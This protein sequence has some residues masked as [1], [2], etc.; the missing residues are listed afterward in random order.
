[1]IDT[2]L[3]KAESYLGNQNIKKSGISV[4]WTDEM[5]KEY[6]KCMNDPLYFAEKYIKI[7]TID[8]GFVPIKLYDFQKDILEKISN[9]RRVVVGA[10]RQSG[11]TTVSTAVILHYVLFNNHKTVALLAN[12]ASAAREILDRIRLAYEA[13]PT[14]LQQGIVSWNK[15]SIE[16]EN[17]CKVFCAASSSDSIR[18]RTVN[19]LYIDEAAFLKN[20]EE[21]FT[22]VYPTIS[23]GTS[24]KIMLT[25]TPNGMNHFFNIVESAKFGEGHPAWN[26][27][28]Y[29]EAP[30]WK[31]PG[32]DEKWMQDTLASLQFN[33]IKFGQEYSVEY[34]G[35]SDNLIDAYALKKMEALDPLIATAYMNQYEKPEKGKEYMLVADVSRGKGLDYSVTSV[36]DISTLPYK[37]VC[38]YRNNN[39][40]PTD[41]AN[42]VYRI[43]QLYNNA[44]TLVENND[45]GCQIVDILNLDYGYENLLF[46]ETK[47]GR[48]TISSG[49]GRNVEG[50]I[51]TTSSV[52]NMGCATLKN[53]IENGK[54]IT[55]DENTIK[56]LKNFVRVADTYRAAPGHHDDL[57]M[58]LVLF[59]WAIEKEYVQQLLNIDA[60]KVLS[61]YDDNQLNDELLPF[62]F[63]S[64]DFDHQNINFF[65]TN[66]LYR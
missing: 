31:V 44:Y 34:V 7:V 62:G 3:E 25:S 6:A 16:L 22:S 27:Y 4:K 21:F 38:T 61:E 42:T 14:W 15:G 50:G 53:L 2:K 35:S 37:Q 46:S 33:K 65:D 56:E 28:H 49:F 59:S 8:K 5:L 66:S 10:S 64:D 23:S 45:A 11:K 39:I 1:M 9:E 54:L 41:F 55:N 20:W 60:K 12:K 48:K 29:I 17:G 26:G 32:R 63:N 24:S 36:I 58:T 43:A 30:W 51:R 57:A 18:G 13:L 19:F 47:N 40:V 52:K